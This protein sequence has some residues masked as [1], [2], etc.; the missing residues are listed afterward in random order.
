VRI[1]N[2]LFIGSL[3]KKIFFWGVFFV[4][5]RDFVGFI[6]AP[7]TVTHRLISDYVQAVWE[8]C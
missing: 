7:T 5:D 2:I 1:L 4:F 6:S 8:Q 3:G